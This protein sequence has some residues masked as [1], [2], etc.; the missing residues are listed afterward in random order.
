MLATSSKALAV[1]AT[2]I[3]A[4]S[5]SVQ[6]C[7]NLYGESSPT[8]IWYVTTVDNGLQTCDVSYSNP[9]TSPGPLCKFFIDST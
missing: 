2:I 6:A 5:P 3:T 7:L 1:A 4:L 8:E 9:C